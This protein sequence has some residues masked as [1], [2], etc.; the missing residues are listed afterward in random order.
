MLPGC[1]NLAIEFEPRES[2]TRVLVLSR[3][4]NPPS[5]Q[6]PSIIPR[7]YSDGVRCSAGT[8]RFT[9]QTACT[10][11]TLAAFHAHQRVPWHRQWPAAWANRSET[12]AKSRRLRRCRGVPSNSLATLDGGVEFRHQPVY[13]VFV[14]GNIE[15]TLMSL[16]DYDISDTCIASP[17][18]NR[19]WIIAYQ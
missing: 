1:C 13:G 16:D 11:H 6:F 12:P 14:W 8:H 9:G 10:G 15:M 5:L 19:N 18:T 7:S 3:L 4:K 2:H 17:F